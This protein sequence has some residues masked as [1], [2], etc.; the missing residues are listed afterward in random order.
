MGGFLRIGRNPRNRRQGFLE[1]ILDLLQN[2]QSTPMTG[3]L[4]LMQLWQSSIAH[5][6]SS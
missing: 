1:K 2:E 6:Q 5:G 3:L 4:L